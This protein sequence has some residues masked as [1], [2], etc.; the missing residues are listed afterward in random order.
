[1]CAY[2]V[3]SN[4]LMSRCICSIQEITNLFGSI[5]FLLPRKGNGFE[6]HLTELLAHYFDR[7]PRTLY[8]LYNH[9][10]VQVPHELVAFC[11]PTKD[12]KAKLYVKK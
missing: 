7:L 3:F 2:V 10:D 9:L 6:E 5:S 12:S 1:M 8:K 11:P 4:L